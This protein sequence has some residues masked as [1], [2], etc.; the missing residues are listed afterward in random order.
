MMTWDELKFKPEDCNFQLEQTFEG[1]LRWPETSPVNTQTI[2]VKMITIDEANKILEEKLNKLEVFR[3]NAAQTVWTK[4]PVYPGE[5]E[6][7]IGR[8]VCIEEIKK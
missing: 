1:K 3:S 5:S 6:K 7:F 2:A 8:V 4:D